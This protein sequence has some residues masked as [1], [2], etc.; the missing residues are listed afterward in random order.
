V[1][2]FIKNLA[3]EKDPRDCTMFESESSKDIFYRVVEDFLKNISIKILTQRKREF[4]L[5][6]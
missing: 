2:G 4:R 3:N 1:L 6:P 5:K